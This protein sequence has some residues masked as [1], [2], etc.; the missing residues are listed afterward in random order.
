LFERVLREF[1]YPSSSHVRT[2]ADA[3]TWGAYLTFCSNAF[4]AWNNHVLDEVGGFVETLSHEDAIAAAM[5]LE[6]GYPIA[7]VAEAVVEHS[8][9]YTL[10]GDFKRYF[11]AGYARAQYADQLG[12]RSTHGKLGRRYVREVAER[13]LR[14]EPWMGAAT[15]LHLAAKGGG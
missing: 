8:H 11:D 6:R 3:A 10:T 1:N 15:I 7:Y 13:V 5:I 12:T 9:R 2:R 4:A 14:Q